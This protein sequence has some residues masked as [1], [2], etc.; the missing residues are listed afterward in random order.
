MHFQRQILTSGMMNSM[1]APTMIALLVKTTQGWYVFVNKCNA[2]VLKLHEK[3]VRE[4]VIYSSK[5]VNPLA[6]ETS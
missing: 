5:N 2:D 3:Y 4:F 1:I 6:E